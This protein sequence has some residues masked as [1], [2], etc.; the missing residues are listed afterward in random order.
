MSKKNIFNKIT[1]AL[2]TSATI[3]LAITV[4]LPKARAF[5]LIQEDLFFGRNIA[6]GGEVSEGDFQTFVDGV[7]TPRF[8]AGLTIF[9]TNGQF[10]DSTGKLIEEP[11]KV[12]TLFREDTSANEV[13]ISEIVK[14]YRKQF[15]QESVLQVA[16]KDDL[17]VSFGSSEDLFKN[18]SVPKLIQTDLFFGR[19]IPG[20]GEVSESNFQ[21]FV[22]NVITPRFPAGLTIFDGNGQFLDSTGTIIEEPSKVVS[23]LLEDALSNETSVNEIV[24]AYR[25][26]FN[27]ESVL[28]AA[29]QDVKVSFG[30]GDDLID[31]SPVPELIQAD[32]FFG[33]N[34]PG[35]GEVSESEFQAFVDSV[36]T[37][38]F[39]AGLTIF[40]GNGQFLDST[41]TIIE[42]PS[43]VISLIFEDTL[44][45]ETSINQIIGAY[46]QKFNQESVL[47]V[48]D[49]DIRVRFVESEPVPE[50]SSVAGALLFSTSIIAWRLKKKG[51]KRH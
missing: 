10:L 51:Q 2:A 40:D 31:N 36:I 42:E 9:N 28:V 30:L 34:I 37:P 27:Q 45:N 16:N 24:A 50:P 44:D 49:E 23:L 43:K 29:N 21:T 33:R 38:L 46:L 14:T 7:I 3:S 4:D 47:T 17:A 26:Q 48:V 13:S 18:S 35:G 25:Q 19:N 5:S 41:G 12:V 8:P 1:T 39:P 15:N 6:G 32:L 22:K 20:G 11:A